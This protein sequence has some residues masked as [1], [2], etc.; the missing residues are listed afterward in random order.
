[1]WF[2]EWVRSALRRLGGGRANS[3]EYATLKKAE[4]LLSA[5]LENA[6][7]AS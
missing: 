6:K 5:A 3:A 7:G 2:L 1:M 4:K